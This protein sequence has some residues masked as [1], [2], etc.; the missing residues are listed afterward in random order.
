LIVRWSYGFKEFVI[1]E[2]GVLI[3][4]FRI[5]FS[6]T[7]IKVEILACFNSKHKVIDAIFNMICSYK[8]LP[9]YFLI[10]NDNKNIE[11]LLL[12]YGLNKVKEYRMNIKWLAKFVRKD[13]NMKSRIFNVG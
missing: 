3:C 7:I 8:K 13:H 6:G 11:N 5:S 1:E 9:V 10:S 12:E 4:W 2:Q